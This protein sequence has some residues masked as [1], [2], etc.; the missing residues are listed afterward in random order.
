VSKRLIRPK[1]AIAENNHE[2]EKHMK[3]ITNAIYLAFAYFALMPGPKAFAVVPPPDGDY[4][5]ANTTEAVTDQGEISGPSPLNPALLL[6]LDNGT[7]KVGVDTLY[8]GAITYL[9][10]SGTTNNLINDYD[11]G[12]QVQ[13]SY[14]SGPANFHPAG[15]IQNPYWSPWLWNPVQAGDNYG[16]PSALLAYS[17]ANGVIYVKTRPKQWALQNYAADCIMEQWTRLEGPA[18]RVHCKLTNNRSDHTQYPSYGQELPAVYGVG[19]LCRIF[20]YTG[21][22]PFTGGPLTQQPSVWPVRLFRATE[23]W[24]AFVDGSNF[25]VGIHHPDAV[26]TWG[27]YLNTGNACTGGPPDNTLAYLGPLHL[28]VLDHNIVY[29]YDFNLIV[30]NLTN[31]RNW[32]Y[33]HHS[34]HRPDYSFGT[35]RQHWYTNYGDSGVPSGFLRQDLSGPDPILTGPYTAF[36]AS[37]APRIYFAARYIMSSPPANPTAVLYWETNNSGDFSE[38]RTQIAPVIPDGRWRIYSFNVGGN[39]AWSG[40]IS[41]LR[42]DP[43]QSGGPGDYVDIAGISYRNDFS[44]LLPATDL[45]DDGK[46]DYVLYNP[47]TLQTEAFYLNNNLLIGSGPGPTLPASWQLIGLADFNGDGHLDYLLFKPTTRQSAIWYLS[48]ITRTASAYGPTIPSGWQLVATGDFNRDG[49][50]DYVLY[51][52]STRRTYIWYLNNHTYLSRAGGP[53]LQAGWR[54]AGVADFDR[55]GKVDYLLFNPTTRQSQIWYL[56]GTTYASAAYGPTIPSGWQLVGTADFNRDTK[57]D[58]LLYNPITRRTVI[59]YMNN[60]VHTS[61]VSGPTLPAGWTLA[62]P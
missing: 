10:Q 40:L 13:Q 12:R 1:S 59:W 9:S 44:T 60:N 53:T 52:P 55:D 20:T 62:A 36:P 50:P 23:N 32:V 27:G 37:A 16:Y 2:R 4:S 54:L 30:G 58:Y 17:N 5:N 33:T 3:T 61:S 8:G 31:I 47:S 11:H 39:A 21:T 19:T 45:N 26:A 6:T 42:F 18:V 14:Y 29:E 43:I 34:D 25:G 48:G 57:P 35:N 24:S 15:T 51:D 41:E 38:A 46:P 7:I 22:A 28:E 49:R 56:S